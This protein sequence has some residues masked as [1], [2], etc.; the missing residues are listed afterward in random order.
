MVKNIVNSNTR[1]RDTCN[2]LYNLRSSRFQKLTQRELNWEGVQKYKEQREG[3]RQAK[4]CFPILAHPLP[5]SPQF[6]A[7]PRRA[8]SLAH[9]F[10]RLFDL[11]LEKERKRLLRRLRQ[12]EKK[13]LFKKNPASASY[14]FY[15]LMCFL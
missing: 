10:A 1:N 12:T 9:F 15:T 5:T 13:Y 3:V 8:P 14:A 4:L 11:R 2:S 7:H 6:F